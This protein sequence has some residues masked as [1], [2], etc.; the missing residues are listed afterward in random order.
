MKKL[1]HQI[2]SIFS[3]QGENQELF[4]S[5]LIKGFDSHIL[6][7]QLKDFPLDPEFITSDIKAYSR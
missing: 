3:L 1:Q 5:L 4:K 7:R 6:F 2:P